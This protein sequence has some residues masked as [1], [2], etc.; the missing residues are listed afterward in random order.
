MTDLV[1]N[2]L[3][4]KYNITPLHVPKAIGPYARISFIPYKGRGVLSTEDHIAAGTSLFREPALIYRF[5]RFLTP[6]ETLKCSLER[7]EAAVDALD[8]EQKQ[9][10]AALTY[11]SDG[12][13]DV[14]SRVAA[15][16]FGEGP[17]HPATSLQP[18]SVYGITSFFNHS[19][20]PN[21]DY[22]L[23]AASLW[24]RRW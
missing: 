21:C 17:R 14:D 8:P 12:I 19:C 2:A 6:H 23:T 16:A 4:R 7:I 13:D 15:N 24:S 9:L 1:L 3:E 11:T 5:P 20:L 22:T 18:Q 10:F